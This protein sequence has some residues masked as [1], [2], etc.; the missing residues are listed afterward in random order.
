MANNNSSTKKFK[1]LTLDDRIEIQECLSKGMTF[2]AIAHRIDK[3]STTISK[4]VKLHCK[5]HVNGFVHSDE[6]CPKLLKAPFVCNGCKNRSNAGCRLPRR[7]YSARDAQREYESTLSDSRDGI[8]LNHEEFYETEKVVSNAVLNGQH[9]YHVLQSQHLPVSKSS[10]YRYIDKGYYSISRIDLPR[11]VKFK[12]RRK[13]PP[14]YVPKG[15]KIGRSYQDFLAFMQDHSSLS[16]VEMDTVVGRIGGKL[17]MTFQFTSLG[18]MFGLLLDNKSA[19]EAASKI[20]DLKHRLAAHG[21]SFGDICPVLLTDNGGEFSDVFAFENDPS[22]AKETSLFFCD[23]NAP[24]QKPHV[25][26]NHTLFRCVVPP[27]S[28]FDSFTQDTV[29]LIFSHVNAVRRNLFGGRSAYDL[30]CFAY[31]EAL[32][33]LLGVSFVSPDQV[34]QSPKLLKSVSK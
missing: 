24:Y 21:F 11:A 4:E 16:V 5:S 3:D 13:N 34:M 30:F 26:N 7:L 12:A 28:S 27:G 31:S 1:H 18:F 17:I 6:T 25:E 2:K 33:N 20:S 22:G 29:N 32:A 19:P 14:D 9:I 10:V 23:P 8:P 15:L